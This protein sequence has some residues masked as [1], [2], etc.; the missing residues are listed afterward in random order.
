MKTS[1]SF[2]MAKRDPNLG[3]PP[4]NHKYE[5]S[6]RGPSCLPLPGPFGYLRRVEA[7]RRAS[8]CQASEK[9]TDKTRSERGKTMGALA[10]FFFC[11]LRAWPIF[12]DS[13]PR[14]SFCIFHSRPCTG[15]EHAC[16]LGSPPLKGASS[17]GLSLL[18]VLLR[19][20]LTQRR[21]Q[22]LKVRGEGGDWRLSI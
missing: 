1:V 8:A 11:P 13:E 22:A 14:R 6:V 12:L 17:L 2:A 15:P 7:V 20:S 16:L 5:F 19:S 9:S 21:K 10:S 3:Q 18:S 4:C